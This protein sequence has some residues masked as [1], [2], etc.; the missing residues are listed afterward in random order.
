MNSKNNRFADSFCRKW[1]FMPLAAGAVVLI[2]G[3]RPAEAVGLAVDAH[4]GTLGMGIGATFRLTGNMNVR[5][6][7]NSGEFEVVEV[8][9]DEGLNYDNPSLEFD[10]QYA[11]LDLYPSS[12][13]NF[14]FTVGMVQNNNEISAGA[15]VDSS[16]QFVGDTQ[17][18]PGTSVTG[19]VSF[20]GT[21]SYAGIG[22]G[23]AFGRNKGFYIGI[24]LG[25]LS[26]GDP[27]V[28]IDVV[29]STNT[30][31]DDDIEQEEQDLENE[32]DGIDLWPVINVS[33]GFRF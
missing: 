26:Q 5:A 14:H 21:A 11:F 33:L 2:I 28:V 1:L 25:I 17:A 22:W 18:P 6:G 31:T 30:I 24:D 15:S 13:S 16:G 29:D 12:R 32:L 19:T 10:N 9:D 4:G 23:N 3:V 27:T 8:D 7:I 20:D